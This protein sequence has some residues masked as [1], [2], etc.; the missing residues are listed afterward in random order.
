[1]RTYRK[2]TMQ[3]GV[4]K[5]KHQKVR[6]KIQKRLYGGAA[7]VLAGACAAGVFWQGSLSAAASAAMMPG[8]ET[9]VSE[10][11]EE[12]PFRILELVDNS[13]DA[14]LGW[15]VKGQEPYIKLYS[16][17]YTDGEGNTQTVHFNSLEEGLQ[18]LPAEQRKAFAMNVRLD[19]DGQIDGAASTGI[20]T[21]ERKETKEEE[22]PLSYT[23]Y[24]EAYFLTEDQNVDDWN[25]IVLTDEE[26][27]QRVDTVQV[28]GSY[29]EN[30]AGTGN[31]RKQEQQYYPIREGVEA[32]RT[33]LGKY[34]ENIQN[35][36]YMEDETD[37]AAYFVTF[38][39]V[40]NEEVNAALEGDPQA[41][42]SEYDYAN[43]KYGYYENVYEAL[44]EETAQQITAGNYSFPGENPDM[45]GIADKA[46]LVQD[47]SAAGAASTHG[48]S[49]DNP[50]IYWGESIDSYPY[51]KYTQAGT[52]SEVMAAA[53]AADTA[54]QRNDGDIT[55]ED[56][57][58]WYWHADADGTLEQLELSVVVGRQP[59]DDAHVQH[60]SEEVTDNYYYRVCQVWFCCQPGENAVTDPLSYSYYG[61]YYPSYPDGEDRYLPAGDQTATHYVSLAEYALVPGNGDYDFVPGGDTSVPV[62]VDHLYYRG[63]YENHDWMKRYV[64]HL[65]SGEAFDDFQMEVDTRLAS[66]FTKK[67]YAGSE[68]MAGTGIGTVLE[69]AQDVNPADYD[70]IYVN[71]SLSAQTA[72]AVLDS[73]IACIVNADRAQ[74]DVLKDIF[75][76]FIKDTDGDG[77]YVT[78]YVYFFRD[79][80]AAGT[81]ISSLVNTGFHQ[82]LSATQTEGFEE[83]TKYIQQENRY[84]ALGEDGTQLDPLSEELSQARA[85]EYIINYQYKRN[86]VTKE[87]IRVLEIMP[88][89]NCGQV[90]EE[91]VKEWMGLEGGSRIRQITACCYEHSTGEGPELLTDHDT[92]TFWHSQYN[93]RAHTGK[94]Y[95]E[96]HFVEPETVS[97]FLYTPRPGAG[98]GG[99]NGILKSCQVDFYDGNGK[100]VTDS[101]TKENI[102]SSSDR[103]QKKVTFG[104]TISNVSVM[105]ITFLTTEGNGTN[106]ENMFASGAELG[107]VCAGDDGVTTSVTVDQMTASE[108]VGHKEDIL[109]KYDMI[110]IGDGKQSTS[111]PRITGAGNLRYSHVGAGIQ[112][113]EST[114]ELHKLL[115]QLD[116]EYDAS[117]SQNGLRRFA[118]FN[119]YGENGGGYFRGSGNDMTRVQMEELLEFV[120][121]GYPVVLGS[122]L[123]NGS[124]V[125]A[126]EVDTSS[127]YYEFLSE[128]IAYDNVMSLSDLTAGRK[129][130]SFFANLSKPVIQFTEKPKDP[131]RLGETASADSDYVS[132]ELRYV[133][134]IGNDS[135]SAPATNTYDC[136]LY[137]DLNFDGNLSQKESQKKYMVIQDADGVVLSPVED[138]DGSSHYELR[139]GKTYTMTRKLPSD[140]FKLITWK[141]EI[142]S[143]RNSYIHTSEIGYAKQKNTGAK[144]V[145]NVLQLLPTRYTW[146]LE[147]D[148]NF[149]RLAS[150]LDDFDINITTEEVTRINSY[151]RA[152][153][154]QLLSDKQMLVLGFADVYQDIS[155]ANGQVDA[156]LDFVKSGKSILF[157]HDTTSYVNYDYNKM[158]K[159]IASTAYGVDENTSIYWDQ[160]LH[161]T[162][163]NVTWGLSLNTVLRSVVGMDRYGITSDARLGT[164]TVSALL[165]KG[166]ALTDG[167]SVSFAELM[168]AAG[169]IAYQA[170]SNRSTSYAQTQGYTN[171]LVESYKMG[172]GNT[173]VT[174][175][176]KLNDGAITQY[177]FRMGDTLNVATTHGQYYQLALE[178]DQDINGNSDGETDVVVWYCLADKY[179]A[180]SPNDARNNYYFY[181][182]GNVIYTGAGHETVKDEDEIRLF[183]NAMVAAANVTAVEP[184]VNF[185]D[186]LSQKAAIES[187]RY[188]ATDQTAWTEGEGNVLEQDMDFYIDV[189]DYNMV[190]MDL[191]Q[192]DLDRQ[193][194]TI[195]FYIQ[196]DNGQVVADAPDDNAGQKLTDITAQIGQLVGYDGSTIALGDDGTFHS[197]QSNAF[198][199]TVPHIERYLRQGTSGYKNNC[200]LYVKVTSTVY[201]YGQPRT[202]TSWAGI[203]LRQRQLFDM[204]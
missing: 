75:A 138:A 145:I 114:T 80:N 82:A 31:Y 100:Q 112:T 58:Y 38:A 194:M 176:T 44:T 90:T 39:E 162:A 43:G 121:S 151:S 52:L 124:R 106:Q 91:A 179:Y 57:Q 104:K 46:L 97:G 53:E 144:Q 165:K 81:A 147:T 137:L 69:D 129:N 169:D 63:G 116:N 107:V 202:S 141:L 184:S 187:S 105:K 84:R 126:G 110:Y 49:Q 37:R 193:E 125:N 21:V 2:Q 130:L 96:I 136:D 65:S 19:A 9:I 77:H 109:A 131:P 30:L 200:R 122:S 195:S 140:Y 190:S 87:N 133:F 115:G 15:L 103:S 117:W 99:Q 156:I 20:S 62:Q 135:D 171:G 5:K 48:G 36:S 174:K 153:M 199:L 74:T 204:N 170:G 42:L 159:Q 198:R 56:G 93:N 108:F 72:Q 54:A 98:G 163:K 78:Q 6:K 166:Q 167:N 61:W 175:A 164:Q 92:T 76:A 59:V 139:A 149:T 7:L 143:N 12:K 192:E 181:S 94:H 185:V 154:D 4:Q 10:N 40:P 196:D 25:E 28:N 191:S 67:I 173:L 150:Q 148:S 128:A 180:N 71:G 102:S 85:L 14:E 182:K 66:D 68:D 70:L 33:Q 73:G 113:T 22:A 120:K 13:A 27:N 16:Y 118:P 3:K 11:T 23:D 88:D 55:E 24:E 64:F 197:S 203:D 34:R 142:T 157:A 35:F 152:Q 41:I 160:W 111:D 158:Y 47:H 172:T 60:I 18:R 79:Q 188:Y 26:G 201:L 177:P 1:M 83:I 45:D 101:I 123:V 161:N 119:T 8:I 183:I 146:K 89:V 50:M 155:N 32:D 134:T 29:V 95:L 189:R 51:Y 168:Q 127:Y 132:G 186:H 86:V 17:T 178:Q